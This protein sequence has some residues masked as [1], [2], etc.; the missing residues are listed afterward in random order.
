MGII[1]ELLENSILT[2][3]CIY[4]TLI[5]IHLI[6]QNAKFASENYIYGWIENHNWPEIEIAFAIMAITG[7]FSG[8]RF[9][10]T[11]TVFFFIFRTAIGI[12]VVINDLYTLSSGKSISC[13]H[14]LSDLSHNCKWYDAFILIQDVLTFISL[15]LMSTVIFL[16]LF[17]FMPER[18][19]PVQSNYTEDQHQSI[20]L[21]FFIRCEKQK[22]D[23]KQYNYDIN[24]ND[25]PYKSSVI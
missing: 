15:M 11:F 22:E 20:K 2:G 25:N 12:T 10:F 17:Y 5:A 21:P 24:Y 6:A 16:R 7:I 4:R 13:K 23:K 3:Y 8:R 18:N 19:D 14:F 1:S 9:V